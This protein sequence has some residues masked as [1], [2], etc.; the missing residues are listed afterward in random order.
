MLNL[1]VNFTTVA[2]RLQQFRLLQHQYS[3]RDYFS[4]SFSSS[5]INNFSN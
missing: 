3:I 2:N 1:S 5:S 4:E